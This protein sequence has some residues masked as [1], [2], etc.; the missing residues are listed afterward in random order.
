MSTTKH[1]VDPNRGDYDIEPSWTAVDTNAFSHLHPPLC[2]SY[3]A[4]ATAADNAIAKNLPG[5]ALPPTVRKFLAIRADMLGV[6]H[7]LESALW[8]AARPC[9]CYSDTHF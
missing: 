4:L 3:S 9:G 8:R 6:T 1:I 7:V 2:P 5:I